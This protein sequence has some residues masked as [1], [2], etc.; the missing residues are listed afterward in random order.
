LGLM[1]QGS[2]HR[3]PGP[4]NKRYVL[5]TMARAN[6]QSTERNSATG[7]VANAIKQ[8]VR[9]ANRLALTAES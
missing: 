6:R 8:L 4:M 1:G 3:E 5:R 9:D 7:C 2:R